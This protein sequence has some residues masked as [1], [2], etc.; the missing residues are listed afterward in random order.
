MKLV[1]E[2]PNRLATEGCI[3]AHVMPYHYSIVVVA[4]SKV[5]K[6]TAPDELRHSQWL[7]ALQ[8]LVD[9]TK[10]VTE[11]SWPDVLAARLAFLT[12]PMDA[13]FDEQ[14]DEIPTRAGTPF[15]ADKPLPEPPEERSTITSMVP[16][17][18]PRYTQHARETSDESG[19]FSPISEYS[20]ETRSIKSHRNE[21]YTLTEPKGKEPVAAEPD[22]VQDDL[23]VDQ[24]E[25]ILSR[26]N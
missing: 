13:S 23:A 20:K 22:G 18:V 6:V 7:T 16:P 1:F 21:Q 9:S 4:P 5:I 25:A 24:M 14:R 10:K 26:L 8:Y 2:I 3:P 11:E 12:Q 17:P 19:P 15:I